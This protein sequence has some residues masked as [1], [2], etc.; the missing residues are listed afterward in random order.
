MSL[1]TKNNYIH[2]NQIFH[3]TRHLNGTL[4]FISCLKKDI[5]KGASATRVKPSAAGTLHFISCL[6]K[7]IIK[8]ASAT[9]VKPSAAGTE[10][11]QFPAGF[12]PNKMPRKSIK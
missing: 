6:K 8:G 9:R 2:K 10:Y 12:T 4:H 1:T 11:T 7:D 3:I 5:I